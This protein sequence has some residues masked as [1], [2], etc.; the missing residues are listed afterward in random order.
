[1]RGYPRQSFSSQCLYLH[2]NQIS[3]HKRHQATHKQACMQGPVL[4]CSS[5]QSLQAEHSGLPCMNLIARLCCGTELQHAQIACYLQMVCVLPAGAHLQVYHV[6]R[7]G[8]P[9]REDCQAPVACFGRLG[10]P[11]GTVDHERGPHHQ[12]GVALLCQLQNPAQDCTSQP[13]AKQMYDKDTL[14]L[15]KA[16]KLLGVASMT[17]A[18]AP[19]VC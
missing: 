14:C 5:K 12:H 8:G 17:D 2:D 1:M 9:C 11:E 18:L 19:E 13:W 3:T 15:A 4:N 7:P 10:Q 16:Y 6:V